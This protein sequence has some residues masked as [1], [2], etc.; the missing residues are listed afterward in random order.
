M[1]VT[2][3]QYVTMYATLADK[4][5]TDERGYEYEA[6]LYLKLTDVEEVDEDFWDKCIEK[7]EEYLE[8]I[9]I[10]EAE[11]DLLYMG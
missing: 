8:T 9:G 6:P 10:E 7:A 5:F 4:L 1:I 2:G 11:N 3:R